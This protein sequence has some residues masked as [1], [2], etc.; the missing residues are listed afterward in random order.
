MSLILFVA[1][2]PPGCTSLEE[3]NERASLVLGAKSG[4]LPL[5]KRLLEKGADVNAQRT[6]DGTTVLME[7]TEEGR[8]EVVKLLL[9]RGAMVNVKRTEA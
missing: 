1:L 5:V 4:N 6:K 9:D 8:T 2:L 7:T 3:A